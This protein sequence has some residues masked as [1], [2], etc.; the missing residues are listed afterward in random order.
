M[1]W[2]KVNAAGGQ[3]LLVFSKTFTQN[4]GANDLYLME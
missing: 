1:S 2:K 4:A 3:K